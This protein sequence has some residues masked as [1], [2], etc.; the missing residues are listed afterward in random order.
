MTKFLLSTKQGVISNMLP[1]R[2]LLLLDEHENS[3]KANPRN[4]EPGRI[5]TI[6]YWTRLNMRIVRVANFSFITHVRDSCVLSIEVTLLLQSNSEEIERINFV[7]H[8]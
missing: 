5:Y 3:D 7:Q 4:R 1:M 2:M 6:Q 8:Y